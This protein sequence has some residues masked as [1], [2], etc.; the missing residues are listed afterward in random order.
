MTI[1]GEA[2][3]SWTIPVTPEGTVIIPPVGAIS[4]APLTLLEAKQRV[5]EELLSYYRNVEIQFVLTQLRRFEVHVLG[6]VENPGTYIVTALTRVSSA[7]EMA[8]GF[9][10]EGS[11]RS[12]TIRGLDGET[13]YADVL[14]FEMLGEREWNPFVSDGDIVYVPVKLREASVHGGVALPGR[15][16]IVEGEKIMDFIR[17]A[18]GFTDDAIR[19]SVEIRRFLVDEPSRTRRFFVDLSVDPPRSDEPDLLIR[20]G[21]EIFVR[22]IPQWHLQRAVTVTGEVLF[23]GVYAIDEGRERLSELITRAGGFTE[24]ADL[25][26]ASVTRRSF[27]SEAEDREF[28]RLR[29][30]PVADMS[31][32]E[33]AYFK[34]RSREKKE[35]VVV[36]FVS[37]FRENDAEEDILLRRGD[38]VTVPQMSKTITVSGQIVNP[39]RLPFTEGEDYRYYIERAGGYARRASKGKIRIIKG[40]TGIW[41]NRGETDLEPGDTI[42]IPEKPD[43]DYWALF[44]DFMTV[45][46]QVATVYIVVDQATK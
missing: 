18:G 1:L 41:F 35:E 30:M 27:R 15:Y 40:S 34:M 32:D 7:I 43:R 22:G 13:E 19:D 14:R 45:A 3:R 24:D 16:E 20:A 31:E 42:W 9:L 23:P 21:D 37:L 10:E 44:K 8:G 2:Q 38:V 29:T 28:E 5:S 6:Q 17:I 25:I 33:Y 12:L 4:V 11:R 46:A 26:E 39:G 36:D